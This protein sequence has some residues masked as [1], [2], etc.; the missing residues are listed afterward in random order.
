M[1]YSKWNQADRLYHYY[2]TP[3]KSHASSA[4]APAHLRVSGLG[5]TPDEAGWPLPDNATFVGTGKYPKG[6]IASSGTP[7]FSTTSWIIAG[8]LGYFGYKWWRKQT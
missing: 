1:I 8:V 5:A 4:P 7:G 3:E 6:H 2:E